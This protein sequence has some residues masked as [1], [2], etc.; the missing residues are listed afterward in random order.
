L[1]EG[2]KIER[3]NG[4]GIRIGISNKSNILRNEI[5][6]NKPGIELISGDP[7]IFENKIEKNLSSG[8]VTAAHS[9]YR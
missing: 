4:P 6:L 5:R 8:I 3:N 2:N 9:D 1:L 7:Y